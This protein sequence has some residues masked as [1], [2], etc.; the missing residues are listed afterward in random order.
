MQYTTIEK[1]RRKKNPPANMPMRI[2]KDNEFV[3]DVEVE[4][5]IVIV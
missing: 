3:L 5:V 4:V 1:M 2:G